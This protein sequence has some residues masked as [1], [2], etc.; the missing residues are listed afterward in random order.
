MYRHRHEY[1]KSIEYHQLSLQSGSSHDF[2]LVNTLIN[3]AKTYTDAHDYTNALMYCQKALD[4]IPIL[5]IDHILIGKT[6]LAVGT[7]KACMDQHRAALGHFSDALNACHQMAPNSIITETILTIFYEQGRS[8]MELE[9]NRSAL[10]CFNEIFSITSPMNHPHRRAAFAHHSI[11]QLYDIAQ[12][13]QRALNSY[14]IALDIWMKLRQKYPNIDR[15]AIAELFNDIAEIYDKTKRYGYALW[16]YAQAIDF[17]RGDDLLTNAY[18]ES[19]QLVAQRAM[20][21]LDIHYI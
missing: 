21:I 13:F 4:E 3:L 19:F 20:D 10:N 5:P 2:E 18:K 14:M 8:H 12:A 17:A 15:H 16:Y 11:G 1:L 9:E 6:H 7:I